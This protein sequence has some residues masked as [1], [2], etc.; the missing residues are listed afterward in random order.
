MKID[1]FPNFVTFL[2]QPMMK[3][4]TI[5][6]MIIFDRPIKYDCEHNCADGSYFS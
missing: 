6:I 2:K 5:S 4:N 1:K 3:L